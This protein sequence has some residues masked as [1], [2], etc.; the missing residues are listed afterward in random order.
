MLS[1]KI[2]IGKVEFLLIIIIYFTEYLLVYSY[3]L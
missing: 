3:I 1:E 2:K